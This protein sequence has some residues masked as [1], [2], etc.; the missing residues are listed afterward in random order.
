MSTTLSSALSGAPFPFLGDIDCR[1]FERA[2]TKGFDVIFLFEVLEH[3]SDE[4]R[5]LRA[6]PF[7][8]ASHAS[9]GLPSCGSTLPRNTVRRFTLAIGGTERGSTISQVSYTVD[10]SVVRRWEDWPHYW[11]LTLVPPISK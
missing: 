1:I 10:K 8:L 6:L 7:H 4:M 5:F 9:E 11:V 3:I 2:R